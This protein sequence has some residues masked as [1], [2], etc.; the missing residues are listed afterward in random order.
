LSIA[1]LAADES[2]NAVE[3]LESSG[4]EATPT[5][6]DV[7]ILAFHALGRHDEFEKA[8]ESLFHRSDFPWKEIAMS[9]HMQIGDTAR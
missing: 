3:L 5:G 2:A 8:F 9:T 4:L 1:W 6:R 7:T